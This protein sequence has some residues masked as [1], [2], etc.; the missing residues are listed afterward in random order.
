M[1]KPVL[2]KTA[3]ASR[4]LVTLCI[5]TLCEPKKSCDV[6]QKEVYHEQLCLEESTISCDG[7]THAAI[8]IE[9]F[10]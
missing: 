7:D 10:K 2:E 3:I 9:N 5:L 6:V 8:L 1:L 4:R